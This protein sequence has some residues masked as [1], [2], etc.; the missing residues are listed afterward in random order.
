MIKPWLR[1]AAAPRSHKKIAC[2]TLFLHSNKSILKRQQGSLMCVTEICRKDVRPGSLQSLLFYS[3]ALHFRPSFHLFN[4]SRGL[5]VCIKHITDRILTPF[6]VL[7]S[8]SRCQALSN[9][10]SIR[11]ILDSRPDRRVNVNSFKS[12]DIQLSSHYKLLISWDVEE[13]PRGSVKLL[14]SNR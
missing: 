2:I 7:C 6:D 11:T 10:N 5:M 4:R 14:Y 9:P 13:P 3:S 1:Q 12:R 8:P